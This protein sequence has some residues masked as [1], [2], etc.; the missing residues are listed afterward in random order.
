MLSLPTAMLAKTFDFDKIT[1]ME[2]VTSVHISKAMFKLIAGMGIQSDDID[3][4]SVLPKLESLHIIT[5]EKP[6]VI[7]ILKKEAEIFSTQDGYEELMR[8]K[9]DDSH[10][11]I[12]HKSHKDKPNEY[13]LVHD[14]KDCEFTLIL[15]KGTLTLEE[16][17]QMVEQE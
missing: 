14:E 4:K 7:A 15:M 17:Q 5:C 2:G 13:V 8:V 6:E 11:I 9:E 16:I 1:E 10:T 3:L 12:L